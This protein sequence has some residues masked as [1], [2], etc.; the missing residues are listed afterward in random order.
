MTACRTSRWLAGL[1]AFASLLGAAAFAGEIAPADRRSG[2]DFMGR[3]TQAVQD[4]DRTNPGMLGVL[5]GEALWK[6]RDGNAGR[7]C[8]DCHG[9]AA[10]S[11]KG[12]AA[13][14]PAYDSDLGRPVD[15]FAETV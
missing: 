13:R 6:K 14:Y 1:L 3:D 4:D 7:A 5:D 11:M 2:R 8:A 12:V 15:V 9:D 10:T